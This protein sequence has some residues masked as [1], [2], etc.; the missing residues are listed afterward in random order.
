MKR[1]FLATAVMIS[2][3][4]TAP[5]ADA[6][7]LGGLLKKGKNALEKTAK[8]VDKV[9]GTTSSTQNEEESANVS[10]I[11]VNGIEV[12]N[13]ISSYMEVEPVGLY[14]VSRTET[15]G[16]TYLILKVKNKTRKENALFGSSIENKKMIATDNNGNVYNIDSSG[17]MR[18]DTPEDIMVKVVMNDPAMMFMDVNKNLTVMPVVKLGINIDAQHQGNLTFKNV[19]IYWDV[20]PE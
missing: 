14:G 6:Q 4:L 17:A 11:N 13:P 20:E 8:T 15:K 10:A 16:D 18:Y 19:P 7:G 9:I 3:L 5:T 12:V 1:L 2:A